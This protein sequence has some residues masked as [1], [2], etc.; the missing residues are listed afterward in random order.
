MDKDIIQKT[1]YVRIVD[2]VEDNGY[3]FKVKRYNHNK[4]LLYSTPNTQ[5]IEVSKSIYLKFEPKNKF[6]PVSE[7]NND[8]KQ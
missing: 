8:A 3:F 7:L 5:Y 6:V 2:K 1:V 4:T